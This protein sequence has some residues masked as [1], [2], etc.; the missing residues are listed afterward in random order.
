[1]N[2]GKPLRKVLACHLSLSLEQLEA[3]G[4]CSMA[5]LIRSLFDFGLVGPIRFTKGLAYE[6]AMVALLT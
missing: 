5:L 4:R 1:M 6:V 2:G 3:F